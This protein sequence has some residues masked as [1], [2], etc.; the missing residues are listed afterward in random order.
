MPKWVW[1]VK[2]TAELRLGVMSETELARTEH[3]EAAN[4]AEFGLRLDEAKRLTSAL[5][6]V[7]LRECGRWCM[8]CGRV[9][10][11]KGR[12]Q[13]RFRSLLGD[14][15]VRI[16]RLLACLCQ[17]PGE[18]KGVAALDLGKNAVAPELAYVTAR[19]AALAP[20]GKVTTS[21]PSYCRSVGRGTPAPSAIGRY[22][23]ARRSCGDISP[24]QRSSPRRRRQAW[25]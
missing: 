7:T 9:R 25:S 5:Q 8:A 11:S 18:A 19:Y 13:A 1:R 10:T 6:V 23:P 15:P 17:G 16:R 14:V 20:L 4:M 24:P 12:Y 3:G 21:S 22:A 2:L